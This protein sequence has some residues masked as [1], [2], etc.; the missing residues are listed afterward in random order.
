MGVTVCVKALWVS[1]EAETIKG[2]V[3]LDKVEALSS[4][5]T[6][7]HDFYRNN[8]SIFSLGVVSQQCTFLWCC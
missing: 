7:S 4:V 1:A 2:C 8:R 3:V 6:I 5:A